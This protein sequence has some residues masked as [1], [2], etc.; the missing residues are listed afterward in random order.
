MIFGVVGL[1]LIGASVAKTIKANKDARILG[2]DLNVDVVDKALSEQVLDGILDENN[3][4]NC[5]VI[6]LA[7]Y[8]KATVDFIKSN[9]ENFKSGAFI[10]DMC[11]VKA[12]V[13][14]P[15]EEFV[16]GKGFTYIGCHP[17][18]GVEHSGY[19]FSTSTMFDNASLIIT[20]YSWTDSTAV[21]WTKKL[22]LSLGFSE[23]KA[24]TPEEH[25]RLIAFT[26]QLAHVVSS[27]YIKSPTA[28][29]HHGYSA[30]S[31]RDLTRVAKLN[32]NMWTE[33]FLDN[34]E[35]LVNEID[36]LCDRLKE[37]SNAIKNNDKSTLREL[38]K[39]GREIKEKV[40]TV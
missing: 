36:T 39:Q 12:A 6:I 23:I 2:F 8:P 11:G 24:A 25:D 35:M 30:G 7:L 3:I 21:D 20:P 9:S 15:L 16:K 17:M 27:A 38:L 18:A 10:F 13:A 14:K 26:S 5:D 31:Y 37:Y 4:G 28:L 33:L 32:E 29:M 34:S 19:D 1:G 22:F 40:D